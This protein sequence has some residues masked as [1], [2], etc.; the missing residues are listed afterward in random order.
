ML[1]ATLEVTTG[2]GVSFTY[3]VRNEGDEDATLTFSTGQRA[4]FEVYDGDERVWRWS[5]DRMF[6][7]LL[8]EEVLAPGESLTVEGAWD[9]PEGGEYTAVASLAANE[10]GDETAARVDFEV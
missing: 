3:R 7:Q 4:E 9:A 8:G 10:A 1:E 6:A 5:D 2:G